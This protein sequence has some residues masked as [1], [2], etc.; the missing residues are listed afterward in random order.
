MVLG[1]VAAR[2]LL[3]SW[4]EHSLAT[5]L[6][7]LF[8]CIFF[9]SCFKFSTRQPSDEHAARVHKPLSAHRSQQ[10]KAARPERK[11]WSAPGKGDEAS[12]VLCLCP[13]VCFAG[14]MSGLTL[15]LM[16]MDIVELEVLRRSGSELEAKQAAR[17]IPVV[18][19]AHF[20][21]V[22]HTYTHTHAHTQH[23]LASTRASRTLQY[24]RI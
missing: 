18:T 8:L 13:Q 14:C 7:Y 9:V 15:G 1:D 24:H 11:E 22:S 21:L 6:T 10:G 16:S 3:E 17:I 5:S 2:K 23:S 4:D 19:D 12:C 20:L